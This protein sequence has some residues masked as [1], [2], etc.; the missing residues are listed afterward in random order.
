MAVPSSPKILSSC[1]QPW[2]RRPRLGGWLR[3]EGEMWPEGE[4]RGRESCQP[5]RE[6]CR[7]RNTDRA[8]AVGRPQPDTPVPRADPAKPSTRARWGWV[9]PLL[10][11]GED[12]RV[13][14]LLVLPR[15]R[16]TERSLPPPPA[17]E[18]AVEAGRASCL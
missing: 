5:L 10:L 16:L 1:V 7:P 18:A 13:E 3:K 6:F 4:R 11:E 12:V 14:T 9:N 15:G 17:L 2:G 8:P